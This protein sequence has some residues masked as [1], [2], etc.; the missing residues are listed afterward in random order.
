M[1]EALIALFVAILI[2]ALAAAVRD[3]SRQ[4][5]RDRSGRSPESDP[6]DALED[7]YR[8]VRGAR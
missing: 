5:E 2:G 6:D 1:K 4:A 3:G 8:D 7:F